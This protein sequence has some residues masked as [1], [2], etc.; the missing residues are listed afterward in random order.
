MNRNWGLPPR[1]DQIDIRQARSAHPL[2]TLALTVLYGVVGAAAAAISFGE[3]RDMLAN[4][5]HGRSLVMAI[6]AAGFGC[7]VYILVARPRFMAL[8][9]G[10]GDAFSVL[11]RFYAIGAIG[12]LA[13]YIVSKLVGLIA[14]DLAA[15]VL[16][17]ACGGAGAAAAFQTVLAFVPGPQADERR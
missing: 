9:T 12:L 2:A 16:L 1:P 14:G 13:L 6:T 4:L 5:F 3:A 10:A 11:V 7:W 15:V 8:L 17:C